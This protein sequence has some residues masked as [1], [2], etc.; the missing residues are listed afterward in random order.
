MAPK[1]GFIFFEKI[2]ELFARK[3]IFLGVVFRIIFRTQS[4]F[5]VRAFFAK[6]VKDVTN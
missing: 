5:R 1:Q 3:L 6:I 4:N 2:S